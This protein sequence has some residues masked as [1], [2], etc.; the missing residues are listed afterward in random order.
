VPLSGAVSISATARLGVFCK[1]WARSKEMSKCGFKIGQSLF[2]RKGGAR[3][4][5]R[6]VVLTSLPQPLGK[7]RYRIRSLDDETIECIADESEL[8]TK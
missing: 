1:Y 6:Y 8:T 4:D 5:G 7:A 3:Q 2:Y